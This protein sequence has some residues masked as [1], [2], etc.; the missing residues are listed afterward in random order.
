[1]M[2]EKLKEYFEQA[3]ILKTLNADLKDIQQSHES[4]GEIEVLNKE[5]KGKRDALANVTEVALIKEKRDGIKERM[6]L[7]KEILMTEM[8]EQGIAEVEFQGKKA[9]LISAMKIENQ[10]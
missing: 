3:E 2:E 10:K 6:G 4:W 1:M 7:I 8:A 9:R 5:L